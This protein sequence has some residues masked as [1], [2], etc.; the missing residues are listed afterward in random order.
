MYWKF[1]QG[2]KICNMWLYGYWRLG[3]D[4]SYMYFFIL[5]SIIKIITIY[6]TL[7]MIDGERKREEITAMMKAITIMGPMQKTQ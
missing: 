6:T 4:L 5:L 7:S 3:N 2:I 1:F